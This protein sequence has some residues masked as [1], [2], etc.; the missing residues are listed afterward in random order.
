MESRFNSTGVYQQPCQNIQKTLDH[1]SAYI[2]QSLNIHHN[3]ARVVNVSKMERPQGA[4]QFRISGVTQTEM[5]TTCIKRAI[6]EQYIHKNFDRGF[7]TLD[8]IILAEAFDRDTFS[9]ANNLYTS[10][11]TQRNIAT[12]GSYDENDEY[13]QKNKK[14]SKRMTELPF[15]PIYL[16]IACLCLL[17]L[18]LG[19]YFVNCFAKMDVLA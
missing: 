10:F 6:G 9:Q 18:C 13:G 8:I 15:N 11:L 14:K 12:N 1:I 3:G 5:V 2:N 16:I 17:V 4:Y 19:W 7:G